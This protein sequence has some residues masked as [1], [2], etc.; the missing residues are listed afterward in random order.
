MA[1]IL[2]QKLQKKCLGVWPKTGRIHQIRSHFSKNRLPV[3]TDK[4]YRGKKGA[5]KI[6][7]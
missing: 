5:P 4:V 1:I 6:Q 3:L 7:G 2:S